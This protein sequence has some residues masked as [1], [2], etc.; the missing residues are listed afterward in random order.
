MIIQKILLT[1]FQQIIIYTNKDLL[2]QIKRACC[3][4]NKNLREDFIGISEYAD[5]QFKSKDWVLHEALKYLDKSPKFLNNY[6]NNYIDG[7]CVMMDDGVYS[8]TQIISDL[9]NI[10]KSKVTIFITIMFMTQIGLNAIEE[11]IKP[12]SKNETSDSFIYKK[13]RSIIYLWKGYIL[14]PSIPILL[15]DIFDTNRVK[16]NLQLITDIHN[17]LLEKAGSIVVFEHKIPDYKSLPWIISN[18][19]YISLPEHYINTPPYAP[20]SRKN[21]SFQFGS[22]KLKIIN[23]EIKYLT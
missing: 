11:S 23:N 2:N 1:L 9:R 22:N 5:G 12:D 14:I 13:G 19:F 20:L 21:N 7:I 18:V 3:Y 4:L 8:G 16:Y 15:K 6:D 17:N 10:L